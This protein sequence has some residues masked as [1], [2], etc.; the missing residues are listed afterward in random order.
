MTANPPI[1]R[2][3]LLSVLALLAGT[4]CWPFG[5]EEQLTPMTLKRESGEVFVIRGGERIEVADEVSLRPADEIQT[6]EEG[7]ARLRLEGERL[8]EIAPE[9]EIRVI[10]PGAVEA[11]N[12]SI[13]VD[14]GDVTRVRFG[15]VEAEGRESVFRID[16][17]TGSIVASSGRLQ[18]GFGNYAGL[19][20]GVDAIYTVTHGGGDPAARRARCDGCSREPIPLQR[21]ES[22]RCTALGRRAKAQ[23]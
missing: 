12:G 4:A 15:E 6:L 20:I 2:A 9:T 16:R 18:G 1:T 21:M 13:L 10:D 22:R 3:A 7:R 11:E 19:S 23:R 14:A 17:A 5:G 8:A